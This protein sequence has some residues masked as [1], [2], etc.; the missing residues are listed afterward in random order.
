MQ[1]GIRDA[2]GDFLVKFKGWTFLNEMGGLFGEEGNLFS[3]G[4]GKKCDTQSEIKLKGAQWL[5]SQ[6]RQGR[7]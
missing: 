2:Y 5:G 7:S 3:Q 6:G 1:L 4:N